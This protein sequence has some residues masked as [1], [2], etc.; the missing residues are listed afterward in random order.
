MH[1]LL[2]EEKFIDN[3]CDS[4]KECKSLKRIKSILSFYKLISKDDDFGAEICSY[5]KNNQYRDL[6]NDYQHILTKHLNHRSTKQNNLN[7]DYINNT[8]SN[9]IPCDLFK[10]S[11]YLR[12][13][14]DRDNNN[15]DNVIDK[16]INPEILFYI[17]FIDNIHTFFMHS[18][19]T[20]HKIKYNIN[21]SKKEEEED[22]DDEI[23][24]DVTSLYVDKEMISLNNKIKECRKN[25]VSLRGSNNIKKSKF[26]NDVSIINKV[27]HNKDDKDDNKHKK[28]KNK[29][30]NKS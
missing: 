14:R 11:A 20:G 30:K 4:I 2:F 3:N 23:T 10:C 5:I 26:N 19:N 7:Y 25:L 8:T 24:D 13:S 15:N 9:L 17:D 1:N 29:D 21:D 27:D 12:H 22:E 6:V 28:N 16:N 18:Y